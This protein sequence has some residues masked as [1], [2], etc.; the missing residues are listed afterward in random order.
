MEPES[1]EEMTHFV[2]CDKQVFGGQW[3]MI[4]DAQRRETYR[5]EERGRVKEGWR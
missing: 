3:R 2:Q 1:A 5:G 4:T